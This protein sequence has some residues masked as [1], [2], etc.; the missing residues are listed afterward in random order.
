[1]F[2][3]L[4]D[5]TML[6]PGGILADL[7]RA[8][9]VTTSDLGRLEDPL[10]RLRKSTMSCFYKQPIRT[11]NHLNPENMLH[12]WYVRTQ[13]LSAD[14]MYSRGRKYNIHN[15]SLSL[16]GQFDWLEYFK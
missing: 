6:H 16:I 4:P 15:G 3:C 7:S 14:L 11:E 9:N 5:S 8:V 10:Q 2:V 1:M 12:I 13:N